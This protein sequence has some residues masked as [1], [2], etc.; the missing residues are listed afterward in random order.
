[1]YVNLIYINLFLLLSF[2]NLDQGLM[3]IIKSLI[4]ISFMYHKKLLI[5]TFINNEHF[6]IHIMPKITIVHE[7]NGQVKYK[8]TLPK[9]LMDSLMIKK[10]DKLNLASVMGDSISFKLVRGQ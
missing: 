2:I 6:I 4:F 10:G 9:E 1:M 8:M 3:N 7:K 5:E